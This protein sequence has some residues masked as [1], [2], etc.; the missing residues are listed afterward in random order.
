MRRHLYEADVRKGYGRHK[1]R[2]A[3]NADA[4]QK[5]GGRTDALSVFPVS[6]PVFSVS[7]LVFPIGPCGRDMSAGRVA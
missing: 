2:M 1:G 6:R 5:Y 4:A 3:E 7:R